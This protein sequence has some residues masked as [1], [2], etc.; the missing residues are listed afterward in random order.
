MT[1]FPIYLRVENC[2]DIDLT[3]DYWDCECRENYIH[4]RAEARCDICWAVRNEQPDARVD[5]VI[6]FL[7][8]QGVSVSLIP[9]YTD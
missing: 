5:E 7:N 8:L 2:G 9:D 4:K 1:K 6:G 3:P